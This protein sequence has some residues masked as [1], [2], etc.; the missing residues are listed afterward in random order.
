MDTGIHAYLHSIYYIID[1]Y[2]F[3][4]DIHDFLIYFYLTNSKISA[5]FDICKY[6]HCLLTKDDVTNATDCSI[7]EK[8]EEPW[9]TAMAPLGIIMA[10]CIMVTIILDVRCYKALKTLIHPDT[11]SL[12]SK[13]EDSLKIPIR[14]TASSTL[15][16][17]CLGSITAFVL[18]HTQNNDTKRYYGL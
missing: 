18:S 12:N 8:E 7:D 1:L 13:I 4:L 3:I 5:T 15:Q 16:Y 6:G 9:N 17:V 2:F 11:E 10:L 14:A